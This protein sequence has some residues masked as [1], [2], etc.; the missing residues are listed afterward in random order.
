[1]LGLA[2]LVAGTRIPRG[3]LLV[4]AVAASASLILHALLPS[5]FAGATAAGFAIGLGI[6]IVEL[7]PR[8]WRSPGRNRAAVRDESSLKRRAVRP[9]IAVSSVLLIAGA[10]GSLRGETTEG[11]SPILALFPYE[12]TFDPARPSDRVVLRLQDFHRLA[13]LGVDG[14]NPSSTVTA[15]SALH[16]VERV[17]A[18][19]I[20]VE[21]RFELVADGRAPFSWEVPVSFAR[22]ITATLDGK[23]CPIAIQ[24]GGIRAQVVIPDAGKH[25][26]AIRRSAA[27][28]ADETGAESLSLPI[29]PMPTAR[30]V[31]EPPRDGIAQGEL[32]ARGLVERKP[33]GTLSGR[34]G[35]ADRIVIQWAKPGPTAAPGAAGTVDGLL[36]WDV[37][38]AGDRLRAR[39]TYHQP[40]ESSAIRLAHDSGLILRSVQAPGRSEV[41]FEDS[42][43]GQWLLSIDPPLAPGATLVIDCWRP[44]DVGRPGLAGAS[45][46]GPGRTGE[47][48]RN[49]PRI[50][51]VGV[52][53]FTGALG[54]RRPGDWTGRLDPSPDVDPINDESFVRAWGNLPDEPLTLGGTRRFSREPSATLRTGSTPSRV[55]VRP[56]VQ[57][58]IE[59]GKLAMTIDADLIE[60]SGHFPLTEAELP[61]G[62]QITQVSG[63][64]LIDWTISAD[65]RLHMIWQ[66]PGSAARRHVRIAGWIAL[67]ED[68]LK[69]GAVQ[70]RVPIPWVTWTG[71]E[72]AMATLVL[73]SDVRPK[74][75]GSV[76]LASLPP[77]LIP[78]PAAG[79]PAAAS[80]STSYQVLDPN[81]LGEIQWEPSP[82]RVAVAI[83]SQMTLYPDS[84]QWV[85]V[86]RYEVSRGA[87]G[88]IHFKMPAA[89][90]ARAKM[91]PLGD[92]FQL[93]SEIRGPSAFWMIAPRRPLWGSHRF[94]IR[95]TIPLGAD[96]EIVYPELV[97]Q[98]NGAFLAYLGLVNATGHTLTSEG[99]T[100]LQSIAYAGHFQDKEFSRDAGTPDRAFRVVNETWALRVQLP[101]GNPDPV[102]SQDDAARVSLA[103]LML[104]V[105]PDRS[106]IGRAIYETIPDSGH[107]LTF[108]LPAGSTILWA[109]IDSNPTTPLKSGRTGWSI[110]LE[111]RREERVCVIWKAGPPPSAASRPASW[112]IALPRAGIGPSRS[113]LTVFTTPGVSVQGIPA[114]FEMATTERLEMARADGIAQSIRGILAQLDRSSGRDHE[115]LVSLLIN[116]ELT[117]RSAERGA[118][119]GDPAGER[120]S[121]DP[122]LGR[123]PNARSAI[124][125][126]MTSAGLPDDQATAESYLG[127]SI[128]AV[129]RTPASIPEPSAPGRI[130]AFGRPTA[131]TGFVKGI[132]D[133]SP[134]AALTLR[135][136]VS[137]VSLDPMTEGI[138]I[139][140]LLVLGATLLATIGAGYR[141]IGAASMAMVLGAAAYT[142]GPTLLAGGLGLAALAW[143]KGR[144]TMAPGIV[145][146]P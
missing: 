135:D 48:V 82:P 86:V 72:T 33:D 137:A 104:A 97:P 74:L 117:L 69:I 11:E 17:S 83:E 129:K 111:G 118:R 3:R 121:A 41:F 61:E 54:M 31:V 10:I 66:R 60:L 73:S 42:R 32:V 100:G 56:I 58:R 50:Q 84:A 93:T 113:L 37:Y 90:A 126:A 109:G 28:V 55:Q 46:V 14:P 22:D 65:H 4:P 75:I 35:P 132:D 142:G 125:D 95:S 108:D 80:Y 49:L 123:I 133:S 112:P 143:R 57:V 9:G 27:T 76:G 70:H 62:L 94:V 52:G 23:S 7:A 77:P 110:V 1:M 34:L 89:W 21:S 131:M 91:Y 103:D 145:P 18:Q 24:P 116:H 79:G 85:A 59:S 19:A 146:M 88:S 119:W 101:R 134:P 78:V 130:R 124:A 20:D 12:G 43:D 140:L 138:G 139:T 107:L 63:D 87:L 40:R 115:R 114:G 45:A 64:G 36:L 96:R 2:W 16:R 141:S 25:A 68:P 53:R 39:F 144:S 128:A 102:A 71:A 6:L 26:L 98:G 13:R 47:V 15:V 30:V 38:P 99:S 5:R 44:V 120:P 51:P 105:S 67:R 8:I 136:G 106:T 29:N 81:R 122:A 127:S 92:D